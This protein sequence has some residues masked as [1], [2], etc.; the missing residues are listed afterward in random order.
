MDF[1]VL[2]KGDSIVRLAR[3]I[4]YRFQREAGD[5]ASLVR[6]LSGGAYPRFHLYVSLKKG[7]NLLFSL[8]LDQKAPV[9][10]TAHDHAAE[11]DGQLIESEIERIKKIL[12]G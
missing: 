10:K 6:T 5:K 11:Y 1:V 2:N 9:Y 3:A 7:E 12:G 8:H 4:G